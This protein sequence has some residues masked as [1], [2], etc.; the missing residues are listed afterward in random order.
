MVYLFNDKYSDNNDYGTSF[1]KRFE[2]LKE[3][4]SFANKTA[5]ENNATIKMAKGGDLE[6]FR[7]TRN[8]IFILILLNLIKLI[9]RVELKEDTNTPL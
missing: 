7:K 9:L 2:T 3:A 6:R 1:M 5:K 4:K 8:T